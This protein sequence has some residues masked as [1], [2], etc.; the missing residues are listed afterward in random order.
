MITRV[1]SAVDIVVSLSLSLSFGG[2]V[3]FRKAGLKYSGTSQESLKYFER[4]YLYFGLEYDAGGNA[5]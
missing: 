1:S 4:P 5:L 3:R 2:D